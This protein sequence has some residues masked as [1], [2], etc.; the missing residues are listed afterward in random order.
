MLSNH[1]TSKAETVKV[2]IKIF[3]L[4]YQLLIYALGIDYFIYMC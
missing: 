3:Y 2:A 4:M 1:I